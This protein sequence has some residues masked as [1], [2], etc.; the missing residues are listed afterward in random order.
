M[1]FSRWGIVMTAREPAQLVLANVVYHLATGAARVTV[2]LDDPGD[3]AAALLR[4]VA[5]CEVV[6]CDTAHWQR[7]NGGKRPERQT[8]RQSLNATD[9]YRR[10]DLD[11]LIHL[12]ADEFLFQRRPLA[13][14][15]THAPRRRGYVAIEPMERVFLAGQPQQGLFDGVFRVP[16]RG[17][18]AFLPALYGDV[19]PFLTNGMGGHAAGKAAVPVGLGYRLSIH[20]PRDGA[21]ERMPP[22]HA[23]ST[24]L[25]HFD[26]LTRAHWLAKMQAYQ[27][28]GPEGLVGPQRLAQLQELQACGSVAE[29]QVFHDR[30]KAVTP[31]DHS[32][33][34]ALG[35]IEDLAFDPGP[36]VAEALAQAGLSLDPA[37][38]DAALGL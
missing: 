18:D 28:Q 5:G 23:T 37:A 10:S 11:W 22:L 12:D 26:G 8:R 27:D 16:F 9:V 2:C 33:L 24:V 20:A 30:L 25:L 14:E 1:A 13:E 21:G 15:L 6:L 36:H 34:R 7:L 3:P 32:R 31:V 35:L 4:Q 17:R 29:A 19:L 38:F